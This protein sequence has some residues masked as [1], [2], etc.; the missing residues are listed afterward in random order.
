MSSRCQCNECGH[1]QDCGDKCKVDCPG[2]AACKC[3]TAEK[4]NHVCPTCKKEC[5]CS[6]TECVTSQ[7][8]CGKV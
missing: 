2:G 8:T 1:S 3:H 4:H 5:A 6:G 7:C